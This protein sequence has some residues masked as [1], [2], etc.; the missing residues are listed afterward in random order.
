MN[1]KETIEKLERLSGFA[2]IVAL[3]VLSYHFQNI[4]GDFRDGVIGA[5]LILLHLS[6]IF[7]NMMVRGIKHDI[8]NG[9]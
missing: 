7:I 6:L 2:V 4:S 5:S 8:E 9:K 1:K 3:F